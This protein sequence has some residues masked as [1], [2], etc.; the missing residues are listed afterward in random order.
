MNPFYDPDV[1]KKSGPINWWKKIVLLF[2]PTYAA[3]DSPVVIY[4]KVWRG[5]VYIVGQEEL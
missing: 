2:L 3:V 5:V 4:F 1:F